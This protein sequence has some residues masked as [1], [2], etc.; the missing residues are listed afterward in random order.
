MASKYWI[1]GILGGAFGYTTVFAGDMGPIAT[2]RTSFRPVIAILGGASWFRVSTSQ[3]FLNE[4]ED[5]FTYNN[6][7]DPRADGFMGGF[8]GVEHDLWRSGVFAD[9]GVEYDYYS[10]VTQ[11]GLNAAGVQPNTD[12][13]YQYQ[14]RY[15]T[16]QVLAVGKLFG[17]VYDRFHP[18]ISGGVGAAFNQLNS[19]Q[20]FTEETGNRNLTP[21]FL[22]HHQ[23][24]FSYQLGIGV[25]THLNQHLRLG[26]GYRF[27][28]FDRVS[29][30]SGTVTF[31][32]Y[33]APVP[34]TPS[35]QNITA[36]QF[37]A[38]LSYVI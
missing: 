30:G 20:A 6:K 24:V 9:V 32:N 7:G 14:Y 34:F 28:W 12:T 29:L 10:P 35:A 8:L 18:Y 36:N 5:S 17:T 4:N 3:S 16:Q 26:L 27:S 31:A 1:L 22:N 33:S 2:D 38:Q 37:V 21:T 11:K 25:D 19:Y 13:L 15:Q 23:T